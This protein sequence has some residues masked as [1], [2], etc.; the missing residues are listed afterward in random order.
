MVTRGQC[1]T[2][3]QSANLA[4]KIRPGQRNQR[5]CLSRNGDE[6]K[7]SNTKQSLTDACN[8]RSIFADM[9]SCTEVGAH[10]WGH[11]GIGAVMQGVY[12]SPADPVFRLH[13]AYVDRNL[14]KW[15]DG[16]RVDSMNGR[17]G[18]RGKGD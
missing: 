3:G 10:A 16:G 9:A 4:C 15:Q 12:A 18:S 17:D 13:H 5:H 8:A 6:S 7:T 11:N 1:V 14:W 2:N